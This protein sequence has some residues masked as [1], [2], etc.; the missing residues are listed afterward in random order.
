METVYQQIEKLR[1]Q[2]ERY[3]YEYYVLAASSVPDSEYDKLM[4]QLRE[5]ENAHPE[6]YDINSPTNRVGGMV[7]DGFEK[8]VHSRNMLSLG[9]GY[10]KEDLMA[11]NQ[12]IVD[13]IGEVEYVVELKID[14]LAMSIEYENGK[15]VRAVTRGDGVVGEDVTMNVRTIKSIPMNIDY[16][17]NLDVRGEVYMPRSSFKKLNAQRMAQGQEEF[18][19]PRNAAAGSIRQFDSAVAASRGLQAY[20]YHLPQAYDMDM[21]THSEALDFLSAQG[22]R[23]NPTRR[24]CRGI[25][26][27]WDFIT[28]ISEKRDS[29]EYDID[30][31]VI[32]VNNLKAQNVLG[33]TIKYPKWAIAYKFPA[34]EVVTKVVDIF[35]TVGRTGKVTP[36]ARFIPVNIAQTNVEYATLHN[37]DFIDEKDIR[38]GDEVV[39]HKAGDIIPEVV[40]VLVDRRQE[41]SKKYEFPEC[42]PVCNEKLHRLADEADWYCVNVDCPAVIVESI[43]HFGSRDAMNID[44]LGEKKVELF[45]KSGL[46]NSIEDIYTLYQ[47]QQEIT[48]IDKMGVRSFNKLV[49]AIEDSKTNNLDKL[50]FGLGIRQVGAKTATIIASHFKTMNAIMNAKVEELVELNDIGAI[51]ADS[52]VS[53]FKDE[54]NIRLIEKLKEAGVNML[55][56]DAKVYTSIFTNRTV[57]L[58]G[59]LDTLTRSEASAYL[60][61]LQ[62]KVT[63]SVSKNTDY[64]I[65]GHDAGSKYDKAVELAVPLLSEKELVDELIR[66]G[67]LSEVK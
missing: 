20:W 42:C 57:V 7:A 47:H 9:N 45:H 33:Y 67:L 3:N 15:F 35:C 30:G 58:T 37:Q 28:E 44:G 4:N 60:S 53:F 32:K 14:G 48:A 21:L 8:V 49:G 41:G 5:L 38:I 2:L 25:D 24:I 11:F 13:E 61:Q 54:E 64:V 43:A 46:L 66:V 39:V 12:K 36:N 27:V 23:V 16:K 55:Y 18:A 63:S 62:A 19:N 29:L 51:V 1:T 50:L 56:K 34:E 17:G 59:S 6:F 26:E 10:N 40:R 52:V 22:F 65:Y 31:M